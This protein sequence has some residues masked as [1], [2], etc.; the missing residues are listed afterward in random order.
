MRFGIS[1]SIPNPR[2]KSGRFVHRSKSQIENQIFCTNV[3]QILPGLMMKNET[4]CT[5]DDQILGYVSKNTVCDTF[6]HPG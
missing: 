6:G 4:F 3:Y 5:N 1:F 2:T